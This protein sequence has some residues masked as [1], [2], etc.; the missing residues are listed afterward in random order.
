MDEIT[1][2]HL[3]NV[4]K[5]D[6]AA[7]NAAYTYL[8]A[9]TETPVD[10]AYAA[11]DNLVAG[12]TDPDNKVRAISSQVL[13]QLAISDPENRMAADFPALLAVTK[14]E[15]FVTARHCLQAL[16]RVGLAGPKQQKM[17]VN[18]LEQRFHTCLGEKNYTLIRFDII[19]GLRHLYD[20]TN[21][22]SL[23]ET[24]VTLINSETDAKYRKKYAKL[25]PT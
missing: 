24:A 15:R 4:R 12:L 1:Q 19:Q 16:W 13:C 3:E 5:K 10:W 14:D 9:A 18:G 8:M 2:T 22:E 21:D 25:W 6:K 23:R 11:W 7:Q 17:L 20:E